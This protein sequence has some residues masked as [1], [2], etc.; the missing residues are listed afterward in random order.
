MSVESGNGFDRW[1]EQQLHHEAARASGPSPAPAQAQYHA[2]YL[3]GGS[4]M[5]VLAKV[6]TLVST[7]GAAGLAVA[8][9]AVGAAGAAAEAAVTGSA[10]PANWGQAV[11]DQVN[12][13]K[14]ALAS[15]QHGIGQCVSAF[16]KTHG[17]TVSESHSSGAREHASDAR[18]NHT[19]GPPA[20]KGKPSSAPGGKPSTV[21]PTSHP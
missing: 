2:A 10:N 3:Q 11:V 12:T 8:L 9:L 7:K 4:H 6:A 5:S 17:K 19:P 18:G 16:A 21:P 15:G 13:C 14:G 20:D 1:L